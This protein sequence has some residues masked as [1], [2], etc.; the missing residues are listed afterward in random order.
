MESKLRFN[1]LII[2]DNQGDARLI[3]FMLKENTQFEFVCKHAE[4]LSC[5]LKI[6]SET[7]PD[8]VLLDLALPD[9]FG[10]ETFT[11]IYN[12]NP[13]IP[14]VVLSG[15]N[16]EKIALTAVREGAQD[17][18]VKGQ[19]DEKHLVRSIQYAVERHKTLL[20]LHN[21]SFTDE[22]TGLNNRRG[23]MIKAEEMLKQSVRNGSLFAIFFID[24]DGM[25]QI[26]DKL[27]HNEGDKA[28]IDMADI[29]R[30]T[31]RESDVSARLGGD[32]FAIAV[33]LEKQEDSNILKNRVIEKILKLNNAE[34]RD[35][36]LGASIGF[37]FCENKHPNL[38]AMINTADELMYEEKKRRNLSETS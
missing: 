17:Y 11:R 25:K 22:L 2:E 14:I 24:L 38:E 19:F 29:I 35:Y 1:I 34:I 3:E 33:I 20:Q 30:K 7:E 21:M 23:F 5:A 32:E 4:R 36:K 18:I 27:G 8:V 9:S 10:M 28:L 37:S 15:N 31:F 26:N 6:M 12:A 16:D 13:T